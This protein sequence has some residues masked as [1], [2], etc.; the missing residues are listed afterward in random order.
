MDSR[1]IDPLVAFICKGTDPVGTTD[2]SVRLREGRPNDVKID[3]ITQVFSALK[4]FTAPAMQSHSIALSAEIRDIDAMLS[5]KFG[6]IR[7]HMKD[8][9]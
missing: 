8:Q 1:R 5:P 9:S 7:D 6:N 3:A 2:L 4:E